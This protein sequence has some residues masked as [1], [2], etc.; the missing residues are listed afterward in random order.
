MEKRPN[1]A[2]AAARRRRWPRPLEH[3]SFVA[4]TRVPISFNLLSF[5]RSAKDTLA[6]CCLLGT[7]PTPPPD[8]I[9]RI[10][11]RM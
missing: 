3:R 8:H 9:Q 5:H 2:A 7:W 10:R 11:G 6:C 1:R 4:P